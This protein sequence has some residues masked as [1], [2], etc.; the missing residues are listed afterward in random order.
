METAPA[1]VPVWGMRAMGGWTGGMIDRM[2]QARSLRRW[3]RIAEDAGKLDVGALRELRGQ[4]RAQRRQIDR[5]LHVAEGRLALPLAGPNPVPRP[6]TADW[7]WRPPLWS[8]PIGIAGIA[9]VENRTTITEGATF[10]HDCRISEI[11]ARQIRN[12]RQEDLAPYGLR[13]DVFRFDGSFLSLALDLPDTGVAGLRTRHLVRL[14]ATI[15]LE[16]PL[17]IFARLNVKHGPNVENVVREIDLREPRAVIDFD[18]FYTRMNEKRVEK[19]WIDLI[20]EGAELNEITLRD[21]TLSR[22]P[23][24][25]L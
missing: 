8:G 18:L 17:E 12:T 16:K 22:R 9:G 11:V 24:A 25:D 19:A 5:L 6:A 15:E 14:E 20:F 3:R 13:L 21:V 4:A 10:F 1:K 23:R 7:A 2:V